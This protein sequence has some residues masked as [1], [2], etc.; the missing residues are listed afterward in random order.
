LFR[1]LRTQG[2]P[3]RD[4]AGLERAAHHGDVHPSGDRGDLRRVFVDD[5]QKARRFESRTLRFAPSRDRRRHPGMTT[6]PPTLTSVT[7]RIDP[8]CTSTH[9]VKTPTGGKNVCSRAEDGTPMETTRRN[10]L[11][12]MA[13]AASAVV[14]A[15]LVTACHH[16]ATPAS[17]GASGGEADAL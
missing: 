9:R 12:A 4:I 17:A 3:A 16:D 14:L 1:A 13:K 11:E 2:I 6:L 5:A 10:F 15:P 7:G 8:T